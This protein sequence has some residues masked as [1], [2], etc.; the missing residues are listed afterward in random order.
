MT[1]VLH[2]WVPVQFRSVWLTQGFYFFIRLILLTGHGTE[3]LPRIDFI[4]FDK[5]VKPLEPAQMRSQA[6]MQAPAIAC[7]YL[8][9]PTL[10]LTINM[11]SPLFSS[12][13]A[14]LGFY[15]ILPCLCSRS[16]NLGLNSS[17]MLHAFVLSLSSQY[18]A[19]WLVRQEKEST[20]H[21][22]TGS[23]R[24]LCL[25]QKTASSV[26]VWHT[27]TRVCGFKLRDFCFLLFFFSLEWACSGI[28]SDCCHGRCFRFKLEV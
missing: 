19:V 25:F 28:S 26:H 16:M 27:R 15:E 7:L 13:L 6:A 3:M 21:A 5:R 8:S 18:R 22:L 2:T 23:C 12:Q 9:D 24:L 14:L 1:N 17:K 20:E 10:P 4:E 11:T